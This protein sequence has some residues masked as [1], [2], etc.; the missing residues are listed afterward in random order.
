MKLHIKHTM[1]SHEWAD[2]VGARLTGNPPD[3]LVAKAAIALAREM[4]DRKLVKFCVNHNVAM[5][6]VE[7]V[8]SVVVGVE[9]YVTR[10]DDENSYPRF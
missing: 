10:T 5:D 6:A 9:H 7:I 2:L 8:G 1:P 4:V 3:V